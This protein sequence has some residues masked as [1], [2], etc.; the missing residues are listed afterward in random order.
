LPLYSLESGDIVNEVATPPEHVRADVLY[1]GYP[2][3]A[4]VFVGK[5]LEAHPE[6]TTD[7]NQLEALLLPESAAAKSHAAAGK[8]RHDKVHVSRDEGFAESICVTGDLATWRRY[9]HVPGAWDRIK[10]EILVDPNEAAL[11]LHAAYPQAKVLMVVREQAEWLNSAYKYSINQLPAGRRSFAD[12]CATPYGSV[13]LQAGHYDRTIRAYA[14]VFGGD[15]LCVLKYED[16]IN[17]PE[18][19]VTRLCAFIGISA[20]PLPERRENES[21]AQL[22]KLLR[23]FPIIGHLPRNMKDAI[24]PHASRLLPGAREMLLS[25]DHVRILRS[26]YALSNQRTEKLIG[27]LSVAGR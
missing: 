24:K 1:I 15:R 26:M 3:A 14:D 7:H 16:I 12:Y 20:R 27:A 5:F 25:S 23:L 11:R 10:D 18:P 2:K 22:A 4:S 8:P 17:S 13:L 19:F 6:V 9:Y 21:H